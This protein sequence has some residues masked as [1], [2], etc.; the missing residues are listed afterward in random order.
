MDTPNAQLCKACTQLIQQIS[1]HSPNGSADRHLPDVWAS[2]PSCSI[3]YLTKRAF[4]DAGYEK[5]L[6]PCED[7]EGR[8]LREA[9]YLQFWVRS[10][11]VKDAV[12][13]TDDDVPGICIMEIKYNRNSHDYG[14][15]IFDGFESYVR[16]SA[17]PG[18]PAATSGKVYSGPTITSSGSP[19]S[20]AHINTLL[21]GCIAH[22]PECAFTLGG[23]SI[24]ESQPPALPTRILDL[25]DSSSPSSLPTSIRLL[26]A[27]PGQQGHYAALSYC[28]GPPTHHPPTTT[29]ANLASYTSASGGISLTSLPAT[30]Q[31]AVR[32]TC[33][34]GLRYLW[35]DALCIV[36]DN[37]SDWRREAAA[38][39]PV[40]SYAR[41][42]LAASDGASTLEGMF[43]VYPERVGAVVPYLDANGKEAGVIRAELRPDESVLSPEKAALNGRAW[44]T[45]EYIL[46]RRAVYFTRGAVVWN[47]RRCPKRAL[48]DD[49][50]LYYATGTTKTNWSLMVMQ[51]STRELAVLSDR[52]VALEGVMDELARVRRGG[53]E[54]ALPECV[55]G[56]WTD[57]LATHLMW[58]RLGSPGT[59]SRPLELKEVAPT[60]SWASTK[61]GVHPMSEERYGDDGPEACVE[62]AIDDGDEGTGKK[63]RI[64]VEGKLGRVE[65]R[66][67]EKPDPYLHPC[68]C[69]VRSEEGETIGLA[70]SD[71]GIGEGVK[72]ATV[73]CLVVMFHPHNFE[74]GSYLVLY[75]QP[76]EEGSDHY[77]RI[78]DGMIIKKEWTEKLTK[79]K[80]FLV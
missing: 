59:L 37:A 49:G 56:L 7:E 72:T 35:I 6:E 17:D 15:F 63:R 66:I 43:R 71:I 28:W 42:V 57:A 20:F 2:A 47:C 31:D 64:R 46:A 48:W 4:E 65:L 41:V 62:L 27:K 79:S 21:S 55:Y 9:R 19:A 76:R 69:E 74:G 50:V 14:C 18:S 11:D 58:S 60:W 36:Q 5:D 16:F 54:K 38:M 53:D 51:Y 25:G 22:H 32:V 52:L 23:T 80:L 70:A 39:G 68:D 13:F 12:H 67:I 75:L 8:R 29:S 33:E 3:C 78:G 24:D 61:G 34:L 1:V 30:F 77:L 45:Q 73:F 40:Y 10:A 44:A 26:E